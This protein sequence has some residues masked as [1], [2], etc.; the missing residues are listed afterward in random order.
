M[1]IVIDKQAVFDNF[2]EDAELLGESIDMFLERIPQRMD[3]LIEAISNLNS[4]AIN[5]EAHTIKGMVGIFSTS[6]VYEQARKLEFMGRESKLD[7]LEPEFQ[8][9]KTQLAE[10]NEQLRAWRQAL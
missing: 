3:T 9:F 8:K 7:G 1:A 10:L 4:E 6:D 5:M 2:M